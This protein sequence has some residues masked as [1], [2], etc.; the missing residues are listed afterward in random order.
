MR[1]LV[2][3]AAL[4]SL[5]VLA[6]CDQVRRAFSPSAA[7][8]GAEA[9]E[10]RVP[11]L[12]GGPVDA[13]TTPQGEP[14]TRDQASLIRPPFS[15]MPDA[16]ASAAPPDPP[17]R[18]VAIPAAVVDW[19]T[20]ATF[21]SRSGRTPAET[22]TLTVEEATQ[23]RRLAPVFAA[24]ALEGDPPGEARYLTDLPDAL[25][26]EAGGYELAFS[27]HA[28]VR[29]TPEGR[30]AEAG[31]VL[32]FGPTRPDRRAVGGFIREDDRVADGRGRW[33]LFVGGSG[34]TVGWTL[35][36]DGVGGWR[37]V[38]LAPDNRRA[39][40]TSAQAG[41]AWRKGRVQS[42]FAFVRRNVRLDGPYADYYPKQESV[43]GL[44]LSI[45][46]KRR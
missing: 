4:G 8:P 30:E 15:D 6:A 40:I 11:A 31:G 28:S 9:T 32:S 34:R 12:A 27:P 13:A 37:P 29:A 1:P 33:Y 43:V 45:L 36:K 16:P 17:A 19:R 21:L 42:A 14:P 7:A 39:F 24:R 44:S 10:D 26:F 23:G 20:G 46:P 41:L 22:P 25:R 2:L 5:V 35:L 38:G 3:A 18:P